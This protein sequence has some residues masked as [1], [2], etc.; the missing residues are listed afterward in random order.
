[1]ELF[2]HEKAKSLG[3]EIT[4]TWCNTQ[5]T[6]GKRTNNGGIALLMPQMIVPKVLRQYSKERKIHHR[7]ELTRDYDLMIIDEELN[8]SYVSIYNFYCMAT[9]VSER[10]AWIKYVL[11]LSLVRDAC[12]QAQDQRQQDIPT[13]SVHRSRNQ[14]GDPETTSLDSHGGETG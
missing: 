3:H 7:T 13:I 12:H 4:V 9:N 5:V 6:Y 8:P 14:H 11:E 1:M 2:R 10:M